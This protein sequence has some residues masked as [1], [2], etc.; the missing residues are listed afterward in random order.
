MARDMHSAWTDHQQNEENLQTMSAKTEVTRADIMPLEEYAGMR[1]AHRAGLVDRKRK[2]RIHCGPHA[3]FYFE[4]Y[5]TMW[6]QIQEM[7]YIEKGGEEQIDDEL[8]AYN[9]M[10]P[11]GHDLSATLMFEI[12]DKGVRQALLSKL[13]GIEETVFLRI[14]GERIM[15]EAEQDIDRTTADGKASSVQFLHFNLTD[16]QIR[17]FADPSN[18]LV[19]GISHPEYSHMAVLG[20]DTRAALHEDF[21]T[22]A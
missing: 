18:E 6:S 16:A 15:A 19:L 10:I 17:N 5:E 11:K 8:S 3:T 20:A 2:R 7:L 9:P 12:E 13:G 21:N 1:K 22:G 14:G 4:S